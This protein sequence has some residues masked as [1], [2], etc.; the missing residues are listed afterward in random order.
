MAGYRGGF[1]GFGS[2]GGGNVPNPAKQD[3]DKST[4][5]EDEDGDT[6]KGGGVDGEEE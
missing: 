5:G 3:G 2:F 1:G 4:D 6:N